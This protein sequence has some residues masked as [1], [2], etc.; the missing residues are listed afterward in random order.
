MAYVD[1]L[2]KRLSRILRALTSSC[3]QQKV[4][5]CFVPIASR[6]FEWCGFIAT[7]SSTSVPCICPFICIS[8]KTKYAPS[9]VLQ[10]VLHCKREATAIKTIFLLLYIKIDYVNHDNGVE[11]LTDARK[12]ATFSLVR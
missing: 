5:H 9:Y 11:P 2:A 12:T 1:S 8:P 6:S 10:V 4:N 7:A 3:V